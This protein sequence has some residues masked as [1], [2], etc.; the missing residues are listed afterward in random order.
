MAVKKKK[1]PPRDGALATAVTDAEDNSAEETEEQEET[2]ELEV[3]KKRLVAPRYQGITK[4]ILSGVDE[5]MIITFFSK[6]P[7]EEVCVI[8]TTNTNEEK[9][10]ITVNAHPW[11]QDLANDIWESIEVDAVDPSTV[12]VNT[13]GWVCEYPMVF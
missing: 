5:M 12:D 8:D 2:A 3:V 10:I 7:E 11:A 1:R 13:E 9:V 6:T 4:T